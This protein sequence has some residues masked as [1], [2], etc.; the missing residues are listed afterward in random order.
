[1]ILLYMSSI[2]FLDNMKIMIKG[3]SQLIVDAPNLK[4]KN[5]AII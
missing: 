1:M 2:A 3:I 5:Y 4:N